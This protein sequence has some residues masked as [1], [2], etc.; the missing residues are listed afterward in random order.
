MS[1]IS[2]FPPDTLQNYDYVVMMSRYQGKYLMSRH[3][4]RSAWEMQ[5]GHIEP[6]E[7]PE[8]AARR[9]LYEESGA[10]S[11]ELVPLCDYSGEEPGRNNDGKG[12]VF[13]TNIFE[14]QSLPDS[15]MA[16]I[17]QFDEIPD[18]L[19][20]PEITHAIFDYKLRLSGAD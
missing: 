13:L 5:G 7:T 19:T 14:I 6:G 12:K 8:E 16:E 9:E 18:D 17:R 4:D 10:V 11:F 15:E 3:K 2:I 20:Y 1:K